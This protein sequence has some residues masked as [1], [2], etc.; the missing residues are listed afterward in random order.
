MA[1]TEDGIR[2]AIEDYM[3]KAGGAAA[4]WYV[5]TARHPRRVLFGQHRVERYGG[6]W[7]FKRAES[8]QV[9]KD[10][11]YYFVRVVGTDGW[12]EGGDEGADYVYAYKK[13]PSTCP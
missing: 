8:P 9:A 2:K 7:A 4:N 11:G 3:A 13:T 1:S 6:Q 10:V 5:G 12:A